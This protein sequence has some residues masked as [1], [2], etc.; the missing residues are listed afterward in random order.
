M[1]RTMPAIRKMR[2]ERG[3]VIDDVPIPAIEPDEVLVQ[4]EAASIVV[5]ADKHH[6]A[7][8]QMIKRR[9]HLLVEKPIAVTTAEAEEMVSSAQDK[10][11]ILQVGHIERFNPVMKFLESILT[12][13]P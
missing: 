1:P 6:A 12:G 11:L 4:V 10:K 9:V 8:M 3:L 7:A 2:A 5:P 13:A